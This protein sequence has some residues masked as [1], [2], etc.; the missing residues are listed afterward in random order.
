MELRRLS[1][2]FIFGGLMLIMGLSVQ[3]RHIIGGVMT[4]EAL[5]NDRYHFVLKMYR[6]C[7]CTDCAPFDPQAAIG[8]Y[9][10]DDNGSCAGQSQ[11]RP[12]RQY[13]IDVLSIERVDPPD[14]PCLIPPD[15]C[16]QEGIYEFTIELPR[17]DQNYV[18]SYQRCCR[19]ETISN[20]F[21]PGGSG[22]TFSVTLTAQAQE[23]G[24]SSPT[25]DD[26]PPSILCN[27]QPFTYDHRASDVDG[28]ELRYSFCEPT[29]GG[30][31]NFGQ[32]TQTC[33]GVQPT[34]A[35]PPPYR[36]VNFRAPNYAA[37]YPLGL[38]TTGQS[39]IR[40]DPLTGLISGTPRFRG[41]FVVGICVEEYRN[42]QLLSRVT[43]D[44]QF[45]VASC[46][47][48]V[49]ADVAADEI[50]NGEEYLIRSCGD[51]SVEFDN[52]SFQ[53]RFIQN[54]QWQFDLGNGDT[55]SN[56]NDWDPTIDFPAFGTY[57]GALI[58]NKEL[59]CNDTA[60]I[61]IE[62]FPAV[63][64]DFSF[65]YDTC[66]AGPVSFTDLSETGSCCLTG[67][68]WDFGEG[69]ASSQRNP[70]YFYP[71]PGDHPVSLTVRD[72]NNCTNTTVQ[73][74]R[75][76]PAPSVLIASPS[77]AVACA[78]AMITFTNLS[79]PINL[80]YD[81]LW[82]FG[83]GN[84]SREFSPTNT[85]ESPGTYTVSLEVIS[86]IGCAADTIFENIVEV[87]PSPDADFDY[88]P[89][90]LSNINSRV[91]FTDQSTGAI[92][93]LW[94]FGD[95]LGSTLKDPVHNYRDTGQFQ[96][97]LVVVHPSGCTDTTTALLDVVPEVRYYL[98]N[99]FTPNGDSRNDIFLGKGI[100]EG[101]K[102][103]QFLVWNRWGELIFESNDPAIGWNGR[104]KNVGAESPAGVYLVLVEYR[105][106]RGNPYVEK[107]FVTLIR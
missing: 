15:V 65:E 17:S 16:V 58:L 57:S 50:I 38:D 69:G 61:Q 64:A 63:A 52:E 95:G 93:W 20:I 105:D 70:Q 28:D 82:N 36:S 90:E 27:N 29:I 24:N 66:M 76:F 45:N 56:V 67:W 98:P 88:S 92:R 73:T 21:D 78:P 11:N 102:D 74:I 8:V 89:K 26:Y 1:L 18:V 106:P 53:R 7:N 103:F 33:D 80:E 19:N 97:Q 46:D 3:A 84:T 43:R 25:F 94:E 96:A 34:P 86:P 83:D 39:V 55:I 31:N 75:Y 32:L 48:E 12:F 10:C 54:F 100:M 42:G 2:R 85:Y 6:D 99:A 51:L 104:Y 13:T 30:D 79:D 62:I 9:L 72:T 91:N 22:A 23:L 47:A 44:F 49:V 71:E 14:Y 5:G 107:G 77:A 60:N 4:Y 101:A 37:A 81:I 40:I 87:K 68:E 35:C 59:N 41:Q